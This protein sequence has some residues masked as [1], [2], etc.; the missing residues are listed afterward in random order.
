MQGAERMM[1]GV[2]PNRAR[3][4]NGQEIRRP[5]RSQSATGQGLSDQNRSGV[6]MGGGLRTKSGPKCERKPERIRRRLPARTRRRFRSEER[7]FQHE[8]LTWENVGGH[9]RGEGDETLD[10]TLGACFARKRVRNLDPFCH[11]AP[12]RFALW[13]HFVTG[14]PRGS[15]SRTVLAQRPLAVRTLGPFLAHGSPGRSHTRTVLAY[16]S[17]GR[18]RSGPLL[19][20]QQLRNQ[21][22]MPR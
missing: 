4:A 1:A 15:H 2:G 19:A 12:S 5:K 13:G 9:A 22:R 10:R 8:A 20:R 6:R 21:P 11:R 7:S 16:G 3:S 14:H 18:S 17:P